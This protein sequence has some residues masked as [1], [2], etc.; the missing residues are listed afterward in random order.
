MSF[1]QSTLSN[2]HTQKDNV[3]VYSLALI[4][5]RALH[6][7]FWAFSISCWVPKF[8]WSGTSLYNWVSR[9]SELINTSTSGVFSSPLLPDLESSYLPLLT[10]TNYC[11]LPYLSF[12]SLLRLD[13][14][15]VCSFFGSRPS[16]YVFPLVVMSLSVGQAIYELKYWKSS[17]STCCCQVSQAH[18][19]D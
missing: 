19:V 11:K 4:L 7:I 13:F 18:H 12:K 1:D 5:C 14:K 8:W 9:F 2:T 6:K 17:V 15:F 16:V 10:T 3:D